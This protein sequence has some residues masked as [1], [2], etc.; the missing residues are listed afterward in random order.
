MA[1]S[2][3][4][5]LVWLQPTGGLLAGAWLAA[6]LGYGRAC[7]A[8]LFPDLQARS[9]V[10][11]AL[12]AA[13]GVSLLLALDSLLAT[14]GALAAWRGGVAW[15]V[16][17][18]GWALGAPAL[19][20]WVRE[21]RRTMRDRAGRRWLARPAC[22][23]LALPT[24]GALVAAAA[25][26][27]G[28]LWPTEFGG[29]DAL[30]Y[31]LEIPREWLALGRA[32][33]LPHNVY[34]A[35]PNFVESATLHM[36]AAASWA[37]A[38]EI[39]A[40]AQMLHALLAVAA[41]WVIAALALACVAPT[42]RTW[43]APASALAGRAARAGAWCFA[44]GVPW[45][46]VTGSLAYSEMGLL[47]GFAGA[48]LAW[49]MAEGAGWSAWRLGAAIGLLLGAA[50]GA[51]LTAIGMAVLPALTWFACTP[52][53]A[54]ARTGRSH[55][56]LLVHS[57]VVAVGVGLAVLAPW[58]VRNGVA[59][60]NPVFPFAS[61]LMGTG[62]WTPDQAERFASAHQAT[63][64]LGR[65]LVEFWHQGPVYGWGAPPNRF[66]PWVPQW[67][68][69]WWGALVATAALIW[70]A[71]RARDDAPARGEPSTLH[72]PT[73]H[74]GAP[75]GVW[76]MLAVLG[77]QLAFW[78]L[79][80]HLKSRFLLPC[81][82]PMAVIA[83]GAVAFLAVRFAAVPRAQW[84][85]ER[86]NEAGDP[87]GRGR[88]WVLPAGALLLALWALQPVWVLWR[89]AATERALAA[90][91]AGA[92]DG[93]H[94]GGG[95]EDLA[96][97]IPDPRVG[98]PF[99]WIANFVL[100]RDARLAT[101]GEAAVFWCDR[102]PEY[103]TVWDGGALV[104]AFRERGDDPRGVIEWLVERGYTHLA[105][106]GSMLEVWA[107]AGWLDPAI[108]P[109]RVQSV[110]ARLRPVRPSIGMGGGAVYQLPPPVPASRLEP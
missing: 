51:K 41:A 102:V 55:S 101:E 23:W 1:G 94:L 10:R 58:L 12:G 65:R 4:P 110:L 69:A 48:L 29:Y 17:A 77:V 9:P 62:W 78:L 106:N 89:D 54:A 32:G 72:H 49:R 91:E 43:E 90:A 40:A 92:Y 26:P 46:V 85:G 20:A 96:A 81:V 24:L 22:V 93:V 66:E 63:G 95:P 21:M 108:T 14:I 83:G 71:P 45:M 105:V 8:Q 42:A 57:G 28:L 103:A 79:A 19:A 53:G 36:S 104:Q 50:T 35:M 74:H 75:L 3:G 13:L 59:T 60:G 68:L 82:V 100:P 34:S 87:S 5:V 107:R 64:G 52:T 109:G 70:V 11:G 39:A 31:H 67:G 98:L 25:V 7:R 2:R 99:P 97:R 15:L 76:S 80:T 30:S 18:A 61:S 37:D 33:P 84:A 38:R 27:A 86:T 44:L 73:H 6:A 56:A 16:L 47:V 88:R